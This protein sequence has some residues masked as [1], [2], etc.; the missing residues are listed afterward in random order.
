MLL[1]HLFLTHVSLDEAFLPGVPPVAALPS[2][3]QAWEKGHL[4]PCFSHTGLGPQHELAE[5]FL[6]S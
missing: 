1:D 4:R 6:L 2:E 3:S 5:V